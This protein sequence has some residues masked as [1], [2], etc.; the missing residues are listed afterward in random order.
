MSTPL[1]NR[2]KQKRFHHR[3]FQQKKDAGLCVTNSCKE[4]AA[5]NCTRCYKHLE[6]MRQASQRYYYNLTKKR[7]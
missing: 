3:H 6:L 2:E 4:P 1:T 5:P 7:Q